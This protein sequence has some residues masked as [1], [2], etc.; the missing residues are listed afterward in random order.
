M[1][2]WYTKYFEPYNLEITHKKIGLCF[3]SPIASGLKFLH[4]SDL[5]A[6][7]EVPYAYL[8]SAIDMAIDTQPDLI[9]ATGDFITWRVED[10]DQYRKL[11][12]KLTA[13][14]PVYA[15]LGNHDGG[16]WASRHDGYD[17][18]HA[19]KSLLNS[20]GI[21]VLENESE[22]VTVRQQS[23]EIAGVGDLWAK[24]LRPELVL[25]RMEGD[26]GKNWERPLFLL[27]HNPDSKIPLY[28]YDWDLM[29][30]G[31]THGGQLVIPF[32][33]Y[34]PFAPVFDKSHI[35]GLRQWEGRR[36]MHITRG[37]GNRHGVRF[38]CRPEISLLET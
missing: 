36:W 19:I 17:S 14:C 4:I 37:I 28:E 6:S 3:R 25:P 27:A 35:E 34:R 9:F 12:N 11:L 20:A 24:D 8:S 7:G 15:C 30:S 23:I 31:H 21:K 13:C 18:T 32:L 2:A 33:D 29:L 26:L 22:I 5:H 1:G 16:S 38:N 10:S